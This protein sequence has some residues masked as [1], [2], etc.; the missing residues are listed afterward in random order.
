M[1]IGQTGSLAVLALVL[2]LAQPPST[3]AQTG[4]F[5]GHGDV[6]AV[7]HPGSVE[8]D[9]AKHTYRIT[10]SGENLWAAADAFPIAR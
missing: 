5:E 9:A 2:G 10:G 3:H 1:R 4:M 8:Y 6:G 7:L